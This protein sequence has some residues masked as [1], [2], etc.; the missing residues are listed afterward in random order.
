MLFGVLEKKSICSAD[1]IRKK[2]SFMK[3]SRENPP[4]TVAIPPLPTLHNMFLAP[5]R[6]SWRLF[7]CFS[8]IGR[9]RSSNTQRGVISSKVSSICASS[10][11]ARL[12]A[13]SSCRSLSA[14]SSTSQQRITSG[15]LTAIASLDRS[16]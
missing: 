9:A 8:S 13:P 1:V 4:P 10:S 15:G 16:T 7:L 14:L 3:D 12:L 5:C 11:G 2:A 6:P